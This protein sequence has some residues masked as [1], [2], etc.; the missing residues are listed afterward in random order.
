MQNVLS[1]HHYLFS[2]LISY[3]FSS[4]CIF[5]FFFYTSSPV[6][7]LSTPN[8]NIKSVL[9][10]FFSHFPSVMSSLF[11]CL[12]MYML[13]CGMRLMAIV[14]IILTQFPAKTNL[15]YF[16]IFVSC[17]FVFLIS[18]LHRRHGSEGCYFCTSC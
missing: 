6:L 1:S 8:Y 11:L 12:Y 17:F 13:D 15:Y 14:T 10:V 3:F 18:S 16:I 2:A 7:L 5:S 4:W 9:C